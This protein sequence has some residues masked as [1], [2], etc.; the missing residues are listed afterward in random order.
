MD[1]RK[2]INL[3]EASDTIEKRGFDKRDLMQKYQ[4]IIDHP[5]T[6]PFIREVAQRKLKK[7]QDELAREEKAK[8]AKADYD[9]KSAQVP[10]PTTQ[11]TYGGQPLT[12]DR[13]DDIYLRGNGKTLRFKQVIERLLPLNP[14]RIDFK[15]GTGQ[16]IGD[17]TCDV[18]F[19]PEDEPELGEV[20]KA[21][22][23]SPTIWA[24]CGDDASKYI[25]GGTSKYFVSFDKY[26]YKK[27]GR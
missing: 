10:A 5:T 8:A 16:F 21:L 13:W 12:P 4:D 23:Q 20:K 18:W 25:R 17:M 24:E 7:L 9:A 11:I 1:I 14:F 6:E 15:G 26:R 22:A 19:H 27:K 2:Y 3:V